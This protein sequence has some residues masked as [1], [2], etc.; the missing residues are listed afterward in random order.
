PAPPPVHPLSLHDALPIYPAVQQTA[1]TA[2][3]AR[4]E[5]VLLDQPGAQAAHRGVASDA[6]TDNAAADDEHV[7]R[8]LLQL[9]D[10]IGEGFMI[11]DRKSTRLN[12]SHVKI[13]YA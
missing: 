11:L 8:L 1:R 5:I 12:S 2:A 4:G 3:G 7:K 9:L 13:S 10:A 6:R